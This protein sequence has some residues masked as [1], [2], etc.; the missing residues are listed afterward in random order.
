MRN[1]EKTLTKEEILEKVWEVTFDVGTNIVNVYVNYIR[2]KMEA[3]NSERLIHTRF[4]MGFIL[5]KE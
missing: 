2:K 3:V 4:G 1:P 5:K